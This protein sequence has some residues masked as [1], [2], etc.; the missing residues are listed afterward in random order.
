M[1]D[2]PN[3]GAPADIVRD[4]LLY[5]PASWFE[6]L[7]LGTVFGRAAPLEVELGSGD[8][9]FILEWARR[10]PERDFLA[11]ERLLGRIR[12][13]DRKGQRAGL[14]NLRALRI[15]ASYCLE[16][17]LP[18]GTVESLH[19]YFPDPWP[20]RRHHKNRLVNERFPELAWRCLTPGGQVHLRTDDAGYF[21]QM[22]RVFGGDT[23]F[24]VVETPGDLV[25]VIT[26][27]E[28]GFNAQGIPTRRISYQRL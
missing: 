5:R 3:R 26:D 21:E 4:K 13:V 1:S 28:R 23:R 20:K 2:V 7:V 15:E 8:G 27:F 14:T 24:R 19:I 10:H 18:P 11:V 9:S 6:P 25:L 12:K 16:Y 22:L 17:L